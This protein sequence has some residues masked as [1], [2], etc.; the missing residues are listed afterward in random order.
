ML[1]GDGKP[2]AMDVTF[3]VND[4]ALTQ[5]KSR[6]MLNFRCELFASPEVVD[7]SRTQRGCDIPPMTIEK[8]KLS[9][10][11]NSRPPWI[12]RAITGIENRPKTLF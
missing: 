5:E 6:V 10:L 7:R 11:S 4:E 1:V 3:A 2:H 8:Q 12:Y 9:N